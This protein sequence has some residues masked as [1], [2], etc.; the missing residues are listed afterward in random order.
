MILSASVRQSRLLPE[1]KTGF[2]KYVLERFSNHNKYV[3]ALNKP[4]EVFRA[5]KEAGVEGVEFIVASNPTEAKIKKAQRIFKENDVTV[6]SIHQ[7]LTALFKIS[8]PEIIGLFDVA[9]IF[10]AKIIVLHLEAIGNKIFDREFV[11]ILKKLEQKYGITI[12]I[13]NSP[14]HPFTFHKPYAW[15]E[16]EFSSVVST[17]ELH[18]TLDTTHLAQT[19][20]DIIA[21]YKQ[22]KNHIVN[23]HLSDFKKTFVGN[24]LL[25]TKGQHL[26]LGKGDLAIKEFLQTLKDTNYK[27]LITMEIDSTLEGLCQS[28]R[29]IKSIIK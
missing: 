17:N 11:S 5:W 14:K 23:I 22:N 1:T 2:D 27:G 16:R 28:A 15:K 18:I 24:R 25:L 29:L 9:K 21:F 20:R 26:P 19:G 12:G 8:L 6:L 7:F 10:S 4:E 3:F 13:E